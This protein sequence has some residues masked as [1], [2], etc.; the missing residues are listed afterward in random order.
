M[1]SNGSG[2][3]GKNA[4]VEFGASEDEVL[5]WSEFCAALKIW[6][7]KSG[8]SVEIR[9]PKF[10]G[11]EGRG[12][13]IR[14]S[15][16]DGGRAG[17]GVMALLCRTSGTDVLLLLA[18][19]TYT[20]LN[21]VEL[22]TTDA[23]GLRWSR[24]GRWL[25]IWDAASAG[26]KLC[27]YTAD[28]NLYRSITREPSDDANEWAIE[29]LGIKSVEWVPGNAWLAVGGWDKRVRILSTRTFAP[30]VFLDHTSTIHV[31]TAPVYTEL[32]DGQGNRSYSLTSQPTTPPK[33]ALE[34]NET[35]LMKTGISILA[36]N[37]D[38]TLCATR[39]DSS[40]STVWI[41]DLR[42]L[43]PRMILI[44]YAPV[45]SLS[46]HPNDPARL[47]IHTSHD[48]PTLYLYTSS[49]LSHSTSSSASAPPPSIIDI[50][51]H[52]NRPA[53]SIPTKWTVSWLCTPPDKKPAFLFGHQQ[54]SVLVWPDGKDQML[55]FESEDDDDSLYE[56]L[57]GRKPVPQRPESREGEEVEDVEWSR[58]DEEMQSMIADDMDMEQEQ[59][60][61]NSVSK[62]SVGALDDTFREKRVTSRGNL[63]ES[64]IDE[65][66]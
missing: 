51:S 48:S 36:F 21:R 59:Q 34:K 44:Q 64:G 10:V 20:V 56:I 39:D 40:P 18:P 17:A 22:H 12:W 46:W 31:P 2:G 38:G 11:R 5:V 62:G 60:Y 4:H 42:S 24:D 41:W 16:G 49:H 25:A 15:G 29:G 43:R 8:R 50:S 1:I 7:L 47:L 58:M 19:R 52:I 57:T 35:G 61:G 65:M 28:G 23:A 63:D 30:V 3:M 53:N 66:F 6:D 45:K 26:Y 54:S 13:G 55:R 14:P 9:D 33:A 27:I 37:N 32:V